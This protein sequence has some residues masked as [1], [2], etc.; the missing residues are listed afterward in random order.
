MTGTDSR[1]AGAQLECNVRPAAYRLRDEEASDH[2]GRDLFV[3]WSPSEIRHKAPGAEKLIGL[4]DPLYDRATLD[5]AVTLERERCAKKPLT[6]CLL[7]VKAGLSCLK[8]RATRS[9][10]RSIGRE[11]RK[12][13]N[14]SPRRCHRALLTRMT[15]KKKTWSKPPT[16]L[17][18][19]SKRAR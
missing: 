3:Y 2:Y 5:S 11:R 15:K 14:V 1:A 12:L 18:P 19:H 6:R 4:L 7:L 16:G 8:L 13:P 9:L 17:S 10:N